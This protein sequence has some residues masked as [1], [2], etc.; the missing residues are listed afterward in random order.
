MR[1]EQGADKA[2]DI[3]LLIGTGWMVKIVCNLTRV[4]NKELVERNAPLCIDRDYW[5]DN[6]LTFFDFQE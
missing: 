5:V 6:Q 4:G 2:K 1:T 3:D